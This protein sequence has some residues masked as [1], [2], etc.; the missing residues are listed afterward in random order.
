MRE[1]AALREALRLVRQA[2]SSLFAQ[3]DCAHPSCPELR[4][5]DQVSSGCDEC[6]RLL[7]G[8]DNGYGGVDPENNVNSSLFNAERV[9]VS[10]IRDGGGSV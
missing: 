6:Q 9:L 8:F 2:R 7:W 3:N 4:E 10:A 5:L 1:D